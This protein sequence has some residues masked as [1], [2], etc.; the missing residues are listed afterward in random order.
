MSASDIGEAAR[1]FAAENVDAVVVAFFNA[2]LNDAHER[3]AAD[4]L[5]R[6]WGGR[7]IVRSAQLAPIMG[8][9][10][11][12]STA[13]VNAYI[14]PRTVTYLQNL[15]RRLGE[16]G[17]QRPLLLIQ[18]N[19]GAIS[20]D[21]VAER[22]VTLLLSGPAAGVG[23][24]D[25]YARAI[26]SG[27]LISMEI[28]GTS[29]DVLLSSDGTIAYTDK[30]DIGGYDVLTRSVDVHSI[31]AGGGTIASVTE[32]MLML[33]PRGAGAV[34]G[35]PATAAA[36][37]ARPSPTRTSCS[38]DF[39]HRRAPTACSTSTTRSRPMRFAGRSR[40]R[41][42]FRSRPPPPASCG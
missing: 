18:S 24:L 31:G 15:N 36:A 35:R 21:Q 16:L 17:L 13:V 8:E 28:G 3:E 23:A 27:N 38:G 29:C 1:E 25:Y 2:Y 22:P 6:Q 32:G 40:S 41:S 11:R 39:A 30:L 33:G 14:T 12:T 5:A 9:Y 34:P 19:G 26:G 42:A 37:R 7:W 10:E 20:V 4:A